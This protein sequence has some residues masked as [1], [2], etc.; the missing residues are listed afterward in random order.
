MKRTAFGL[1]IITLIAFALRIYHLD[2]VSLRGD[3]AFTVIFVQRTWDGLWKGIRLIEPNPPLLYL[4]L[5]GWIALA[6]AT[7]FATRYLSVFFG[8]LC[9][10][11]VYRLAR[12]MFAITRNPISLPGSGEQRNR[13]SGEGTTGTRVAIL[14][15]ALIAINPYQVWHSQ[16]VRNYTLWPALSLLSL[17]FLWRW[18]REE[19]KA[20][21]GRQEAESKFET[22]NSFEIRNSNFDFRILNLS[23]YTLAALAS[24]YTH[25]YDAFIL[26]AENLF[27]L[28]TLRRKWRSLARWFGAQAVLAVTYLPWVLFFTNRVTTYGEASA[29]QSV[30]LWDQFGRTLATFVLSDTVPE[31][32]KTVLWIPLAL[33]LGAILVS[34]AR[35]G[36]TAKAGFLALYIGIP[37]LALYAISI[38]RPLFLERY[39]NGVAPGYYIV[40]AAGLAALWPRPWTRNSTQETATLRSRLTSAFRGGGMT[41]SRLQWSALAVAILFFVFTCGYALANYY[42]D[43]AYAK[44]PNWRA[45]AQFITQRRQEGDQ[46]I[47]NFNEMSAIYYL[48]GAL[49]V[50]TL[51][52]DYWAKPEDE[53]TL[54]QLNLER[55]RLWLIPA[56]PDFWDSDHFVENYLSRYADRE[57]DTRV[58]EF[59]LQLYATRREFEPQIQPVNARVG[60]ATLVG[61]RLSGLANGTTTLSGPMNLHVVLYWRPEQKVEK[62]WTV[63]VHLLDPSG[64]IVAQEDQAPVEG[65]YPTTRWQPG[66]LIVDAYDLR[67]NGSPGEYALVAGMYDPTSLVRAPALD[68][69]GTRLAEDRVPLTSMT[70]V[71]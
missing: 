3:E 68:A 47:Q 48:G 53:D 11:L 71:P 8:V 55:R 37:T 42:F 51:P 41:V 59:R 63:F 5:R 1:L 44:A 52:R 22:R 24:L 69:N 67:A 21:G 38:G 4:A 60:Q 18:W 65:T 36:E 39:L 30:P 16:D 29:Q 40:F 2:F 7:E 17:I 43:P 54:R 57:L 12:G 64:R 35:R 32:L 27:V 66:E 19:R 13:V 50:M 45:L 28:I 20:V 6:G 56:P 26:V 9:V 25:Y 14:A 23:L 70:V 10:P 33:A 34:L 49:P 62:D 31:I 61:Y 46:V 58:G 15:A